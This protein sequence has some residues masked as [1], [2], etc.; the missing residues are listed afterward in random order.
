MPSFSP[1]TTT[2]SACVLLAA[3]SRAAPAAP[4]APVS[5]TV[6]AARTYEF[7]M[8]LEGGGQETFFKHNAKAVVAAE[9]LE[10]FRALVGD[11]EDTLVAALYGLK[12]PT[13]ALNGYNAWV[14]APSRYANVWS[15]PA[16]VR[17][18]KFFRRKAS[19][20]AYS[21][22]FDISILTDWL[23]AQPRLTLS[24]KPGDIAEIRRRLVVILR[25]TMLARNCDIHSITDNVMR[26]DDGNTLYLEVKRKTD[27]SALRNTR[28]VSYSPSAT[29]SQ[30]VSCGTSQGNSTW[31][32]G[33]AENQEKEKNTVK[34]LSMFQIS[35]FTKDSS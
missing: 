25:L 27:N 20:A 5:G 29:T 9:K 16:A 8:A 18:V 30:T 28:T 11:H 17:A 24:A 3:R 22:F 6:V 21:E 7:D 12:Q 2:T 32:V 10:T 4:D 23:A 13:Q 14:L 15:L 35:T 31:V 19:N 26:S 33:R 34:D 1:P